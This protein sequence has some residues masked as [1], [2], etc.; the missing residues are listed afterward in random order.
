MGNKGVVIRHAYA[1]M[2]MTIRTATQSDAYK[3][4]HAKRAGH[5]SSTANVLIRMGL[6]VPAG[7][8]SMLHNGEHPEYILAASLASSQQGE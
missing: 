1:V 2:H 3:A 5:C 8:A 6:N 4:C 7:I